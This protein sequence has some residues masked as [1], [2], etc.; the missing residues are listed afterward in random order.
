MNQP[1]TD[2][3]PL[4]GGTCLHERCAWWASLDG[5]W[6]MG[7]VADHLRD[8]ADSLNDLATAAR[9]EENNV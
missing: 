6:C 3:C 8:I 5:T 1:P 4:I 2:I 9:K 7:A